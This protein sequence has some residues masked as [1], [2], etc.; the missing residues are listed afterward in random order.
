MYVLVT[1]SAKESVVV[2]FFSKPDP[3]WV[4]HILRV[5][6][7]GYQT[8]LT[9]RA[10]SADGLVKLLNDQL[11]FARPAEFSFARFHVIIGECLITALGRNSP[12]HSF[13]QPCTQCSEYIVEVD[14]HTDDSKAVVRV[15]RTGSV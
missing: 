9:G 11:A 2:G 5:E 4:A 7:P 1:R 14:P 13:W 12:E 6:P 10:K 15:N 8:L 3:L